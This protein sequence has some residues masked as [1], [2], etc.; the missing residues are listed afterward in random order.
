[1]NR[2]RKGSPPPYFNAVEDAAGALALQLR[3]G[4]VASAPLRD[5]LGAPILAA[6]RLPAEEARLARPP[7]SA[8]AIEH[9]RY[10]RVA[11]DR[12]GEEA[13]RRPVRQPAGCAACW[14][15][16]AAPPARAL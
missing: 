2:K 14:R 11:E 16:L 9:D 8:N 1:M 3:I 4:A 5:W 13:Q 15:S 7:P 10:H 12:A 6:R